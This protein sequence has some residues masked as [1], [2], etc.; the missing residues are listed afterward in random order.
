MR[1]KLITKQLIDLFQSPP[2]RLRIDEDV[3][4]QRDDVEHKEDI[5]V[6]QSNTSQSVRRE[7]RKDEIDD[8][9]SE[10]RDTVSERSHFDR[11]DFRGDYP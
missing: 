6:S 4:Q 8:P 11:E 2:L 1:H 3:R 9:V 10:R 7:L 5:E